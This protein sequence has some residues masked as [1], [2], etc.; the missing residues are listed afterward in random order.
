MRD[1][2][3]RAWCEGT[4]GNMTVTKPFMDYDVTIING[5]YASVEGGWDIHG[6]YATIPLMQYTGLKD[7]NGREIYEGDILQ[8]AHYKGVVRY[9]QDV[10]QFMIEDPAT[11][12]YPDTTWRLV[13]NKNVVIGNIYE[14]PELLT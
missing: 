12:Q 8:W 6:T 14:N 9:K 2:K 1:I 4:H 11:P 10:C 5:K 13:D 7:K 3:F